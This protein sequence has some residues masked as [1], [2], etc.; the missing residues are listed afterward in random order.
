MQKAGDAN[1]ADQAKSAIQV[2]C[3]AAAVEPESV[4]DS[5]LQTRNARRYVNVE[6]INAVRAAISSP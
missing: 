3:Q 5:I 4:L 2:T 1:E 6:L